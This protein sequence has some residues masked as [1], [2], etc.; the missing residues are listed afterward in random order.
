[1]SGKCRPSLRAKTLENVNRSKLSQTD[2]DCIQ[3]VFER[4]IPKKPKYKSEYLMHFCPNCDY[5]LPL[6]FK[7]CNHCGQAVDWRIPNER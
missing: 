4:F 6:S 2:K 5:P 3:A 7:F 1:M